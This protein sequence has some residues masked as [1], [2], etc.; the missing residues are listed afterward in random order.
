MKRSI[1]ITV[2]IFIVSAGLLSFLIWNRP[3]IYKGP[4]DDL[5]LGNTP[6]FY[7]L[8]LLVAEERGFFTQNGLNVSMKDY[9]SGSVALEG[10]LN[11]DV[12]MA[13]AADF[14]FVNKSFER[15]DLRIVASIGTS[16]SEEIV[17]RKDRNI[18]QIRDL[19]AKRVGVSLNTSAEF[20][21]MRFLLFNQIKLEEVT[22]VNLG[23]ARL[24][25]AIADGEV[26]AVI[27]WDIWVHEAKKRLG[28]NAVNWPARI[29]QDY[30]W[31]VI[32]TAGLIDRKPAAIERFLKALVQAEEFV[33]TN[34][35]EAKAI[36]TRRRN[37]EPAYVDYAWK[38]NRF[39][40]SLDQGILTA[41]DGEADW[42]LQGMPAGKRFVPNYLRFIYMD[43][44]DAVKP[45][46]NTILR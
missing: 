16:G 23:P 43:G 45:T 1:W 12:D 29:G 7:S 37:R 25:D 41:M 21:L 31:L 22:L 38:K 15:D 17:A 44:L 13:V 30:Y 36:F 42:R 40:V 4:F 5:S 39:G 18:G 27:I 46:A 14:A 6:V 34:E 20:T 3:S 32:T 11:G 9:E 24:V 2:T 8:L 10:L 33:N 26:D 19:K 35:T 28:L